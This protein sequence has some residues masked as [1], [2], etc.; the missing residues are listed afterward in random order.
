MQKSSCVYDRLLVYLSYYISA[1]FTQTRL[2]HALDKIFSCQQ[3]LVHD[4]EIS[5]WVLQ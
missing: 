3:E 2:Q 4:N 5:S 1:H